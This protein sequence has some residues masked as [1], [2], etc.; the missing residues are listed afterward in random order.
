LI[1]QSPS[2]FS[3]AAETGERILA[4]YFH[5]YGEGGFDWA[6]PTAVPEPGTA[7]L[8]ALFALL[9]SCQRRSSRGNV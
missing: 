7:G 3:P 1:C 2:A 9:L 5:L 6:H 8:L 4:E